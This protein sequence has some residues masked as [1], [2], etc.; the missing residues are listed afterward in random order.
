MVVQVSQTLEE[1]SKLYFGGCTD[2]IV[3]QGTVTAKT[4]PSAN[5]TISIL[6]DNFITPGV[7]S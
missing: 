3:L 1:N 2:Q 5:R 7:G 4:Y 6:I